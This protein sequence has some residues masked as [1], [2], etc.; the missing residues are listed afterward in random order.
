MDKGKVGQSMIFVEELRILLQTDTLIDQV[1]SSQNISVN[2]DGVNNNKYVID[3]TQSSEDEVVYDDTDERN[4]D[5]IDLTISS[6]KGTVS[7][8]DDVRINTAKDE[9]VRDD[10][11]V[12]NNNDSNF[13]LFQSL[14]LIHWENNSSLT[15]CNE[16]PCLDLHCCNENNHVKTTK[17]EVKS[18]TTNDDYANNSIAV[19]HLLIEKSDKINVEEKYCVISSKDHGNW[20]VLYEDLKIKD[21]EHTKE[22]NALQKEIEELKGQILLAKSHKHELEVLVLQQNDVSTISDS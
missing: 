11:D 5:P 8:D 17:D 15:L 4:N 19:E 10:K 6:D 2:D 21:D 18:T 12:T 13:R 22:H 16:V 20:K 1:L 9:S 7:D 3:I 14:D